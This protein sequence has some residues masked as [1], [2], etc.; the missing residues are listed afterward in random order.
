MKRQVV[1]FICVSLVCLAGMAHADL[2]VHG[3]TVVDDRGTAG[4]PSDDL[5]FYRDLS[6]FTNMDYNEQKTAIAGL[7]AILSGTGP[8]RMATSADMG[9]IIGNASQVMDTFLPSYGTDWWKARYDQLGATP[10]GGPD[11][12]MIYEII[13]GSPPYT[14][15]YD[16]PWSL[17]EPSLGAWAVT[18]VVPIPG[19]VLLG[20]LGLAV[21]GYR[22]RRSR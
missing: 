9:G 10:S 20:T 21:A 14:E 19:A 5:Y 2:S 18:N 6:A 13:D 12:Y 8:W 3:Q 17:E 11:E 16:K 7:S 22:L 1:S 15:Q 4:D